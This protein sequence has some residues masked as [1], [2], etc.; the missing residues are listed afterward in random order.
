MKNPRRTAGEAHKGLE[1]E[2]APRLEPGPG[3]GESARSADE[4]SRRAMLAVLAD[5]VATFR[6]TAAL[7][8]P[9]DASL[10]AATVHWFASDESRE[11]WSFVAVCHAL[12][13]DAAQIRAGLKDVR[14]RARLARERRVLH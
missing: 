14:R 6:R 4:A 9:G 1:T 11:P 10:F 7:A 12:G 8:G 5:A 2:V 3:T 13:L